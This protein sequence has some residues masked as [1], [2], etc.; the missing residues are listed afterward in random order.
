V[1]VGVGLGVLLGA[2]MVAVGRGVSVRLGVGVAATVDVVQTVALAW[3]V[4]A[5]TVSES[6]LGKTRSEC[7]IGPLSAQALRRTASNTVV[8]NALCTERTLVLDLNANLAGRRK[9]TSGV[10]DR[11]LKPIGAIGDGTGVQAL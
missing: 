9:V 10:D 4:E 5:I 7:G 6:W 2:T 8:Y 1:A 11:Q 3:V